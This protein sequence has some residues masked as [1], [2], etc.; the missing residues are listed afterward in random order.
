MS[1]C[2]SRGCVSPGVRE[3]CE[4]ETYYF[5]K[6]WPHGNDIERGI[7]ILA[8]SK[9]IPK[10]NSSNIFCLSTHPQQG[11]SWSCLKNRHKISLCEHQHLYVIPQKLF[12]IHRNTGKWW[13][14]DENPNNTLLW[15]LLEL[16][17]VHQLTRSLSP[18]PQRSRETRSMWEHK[19]RTQRKGLSAWAPLRP[20]PRVGMRCIVYVCY[21]CVRLMGVCSA[22]LGPLDPAQYSFPTHQTHNLF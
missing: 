15:V 22:S 21:V 16:C 13:F 10:A 14:M 7:E 8:L 11:T 9:M 12:C 4:L 20:A 17:G 6:L 5:I 2:D 18:Q 1:F 19:L 3:L